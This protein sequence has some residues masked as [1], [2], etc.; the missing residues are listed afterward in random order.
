MSAMTSNATGKTRQ[1]AEPEPVETAPSYSPTADIIETDQEFTLL[2]DMPGVKAGDVV[3][4]YDDGVLSIHGRVTGRQ[5]DGQ[6]FVQ[7]EYGV[8]DFRRAFRVGTEVDPDGI[9]AELRNGELTLHVPKAASA[10]VR[11]IPVRGS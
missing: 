1:P 5:A 2:I 9:R 4:T 11:R 3:A 8:G 10:R 7:R 6:A